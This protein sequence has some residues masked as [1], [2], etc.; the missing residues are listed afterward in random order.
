MPTA[1]DAQVQPDLQHA[2]D[3]AMRSGQP[4]LI[5]RDGE[6][7]AALVTLDHLKALEAKTDESPRGAVDAI[8]RL[9]RDGGVVQWIWDVTSQRFLSGLPERAGL[10]S[11]TAEEYLA[12]HATPETRLDSIH[13]QDRDRYGRD[14]EDGLRSRQHFQIEFRERTAE[15]SYR[16]FR[17][18]GQ[19]FESDGGKRLLVAGM[20]ADITARKSIETRLT[21]SEA[22]LRQAADMAQLG[23]WV[24]DEV[25]DRCIYCSKTLA[26]MFDLTPEAY[27]E[28]YATMESLI[29]L[30]HPADRD[31]YDKVMAEARETA[32]GYDIEYRER[33]S[34]GTYRYLRERGEPV[35]DANGL[36]VRHV[37]T[38]Q[39][40]TH[41]KQTEAVLLH[42]RDEL[43]ARVRH[44]TEQLHQTN[45]ELRR[46]IAER[47]QAERALRESHDRLRLITDNLPALIMY[48][49]RDMRY[50]F[51]NSTGAR[52]HCRAAEEF[53][54]K[55]IAE[56]NE[57]NFE[58]IK[59]KIEAALSG[60]TVTFETTLSYYDGHTRDLRAVYVPHRDESGD[61][62]GFIVLAEDITKDKQ[63][64]LALRHA[65]KMEA[66]GQLSGGAAHDFNNLLEIIRGNADLL[67]EGT[68]DST[69]LIAGIQRA[70]RLAQDLTQRLLAF[71]R[72]Q[73]LEPKP[74]HL[75]ELIDGTDQLLKRTLG[76]T[77]TIER[78]LQD[79]L[80]P[81]L[82]D[83]GQVENALLNLAIN[84][85]DA[86]PLGGRLTIE[87]VNAT[88]DE[89]TA[90]DFPGICDGDYVVLTVKDS[91]EGMN[92]ETLARATE[93]F[94]T[95]KG[96]GEGTGLGLSMVYGFAEQSGGHLSIISDEGVGTT[97]RLYLPRAKSAP[98]ASA[99]R[100]TSEVPVGRGESILLVEDDSE[101]RRLLVRMLEGLG[102]RVSEVGDAAAALKGL[103]RSHSTDVLLSDVVLPGDLSGTELAERFRQSSPRT[104]LIFMTGYSPEA[105]GNVGI[106]FADTHLLRKPFSKMD[107]ALKLREVLDA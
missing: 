105:A 46:E 68:E 36:L 98:A 75:N 81:V 92:D 12:R 69:E 67:L 97:V 60:E 34:D 102:Y 93:P 53:V 80:W 88:P 85:R 96:L 100:I 58:I 61:V 8:S 101:V 19:A 11:L 3:R 95:T 77:I 13:P 35:L 82:A 42:A 89:Q 106:D 14:F 64:E 23:H 50:R 37:G 21:E 16:H 104:K 38:L 22:L 15:G 52:W 33:S 84:A 10:L 76:V 99:P 86:M 17:E 32:T 4:Q 41:Y 27:L 44:R 26:D 55:T 28:K 91:G 43:E 94:F 5:H 65:Q 47:Q 9:Q 73:P 83:P 66:V 20:T 79:G 59:P 107:L 71:S 7:A 18:Y 48:A 57:A 31:R 30:V 74:F 63:A 87:A 24:W 56:I 62:C 6:A 70:G 29:E 103:A 25:E 2:F 49:D 40:M 90:A 39:D 51:I 72:R 54:G 45:K 78:C 1:V